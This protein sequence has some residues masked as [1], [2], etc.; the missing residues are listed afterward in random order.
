MARP[1]RDKAT[2]DD[3][4]KI[5]IQFR[6]AL[7]AVAETVGHLRKGL[8]KHNI[9]SSDGREVEI[10]GDLDAKLIGALLL[11]SEGEDLSCLYA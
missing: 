10:E 11:L 1:S 4:V 6:P 7:G 8:P 5:F 3:A 2:R 9:G